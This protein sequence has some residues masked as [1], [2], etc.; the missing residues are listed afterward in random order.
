MA[1]QNTLTARLRRR[2]TLD[3]DDDRSKSVVH[4]RVK[5]QD[6]VSKH[7]TLNDKLGEGT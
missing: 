5:H 2:L 4:I 6:E 1:E 3:D 7:L